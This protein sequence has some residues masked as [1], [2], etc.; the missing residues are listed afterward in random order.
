MLTGDREEGELHMRV[1][2]QYILTG[3]LLMLAGFCRMG[4]AD[5]CRA[6][7]RPLYLYNGQQAEEVDGEYISEG[8]LYQAG[9]TGQIRIG[10]ED[11]TIY[12]E[13]ARMEFLTSNKAI[14]QV[15]ENGVYKVT[16]GGKAVVT[17]NGY[18]SEGVRLFSASYCFRCC[19]DVSGAVLQKTEL[20]TYIINWQTKEA[21]VAFKNM[22]DLTYHT[23]SWTSSYDGMDIE[24]VLDPET[25]TLKIFSGNKG[26][27]TLTIYINNKAFTL[28]IITA[29]VQ[30]NKI[31]AVLTPKKK[32]TLKIKGYPE[33]IKWK[34]M[35]KKVATISSKG[36][37]KA[38]KTGNTVVY[39]IVDGQKVGCAVSVVTTKIKKVISTAKKT[40]K[41]KYS[42]PKRMKKGYYDC[43]SLVWR[44]YKKIGKTFGDRHYA[45]VAAN[46]AKYLFKKNKRIKGGLDKKNIQG[47]KLRPGDLMFCTGAKNGRYKGIYHVEMFVG[48]Q[49]EGFDSKGKPILGTLWAARPAN[50]YFGYPMG[51][52]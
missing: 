29:E 13:L 37:I 12:G 19:A 17:A 52:P 43:S 41:G 9:D 6:A 15:D 11:G 50:H 46:I 21:V 16:G 1:I 35:K 2:R 32:T 49:C 36:V 28:K 4:S 22:P 40:A 25:K 48:Y 33:K 18:D 39:A 34:T 42:Q 5:P 23:F 14:V 31:S 47:M 8:E 20:R 3:I 51:R 45:P 38:K 44:S 26:T 27:T 30:I 24:C 10:Y 7:E